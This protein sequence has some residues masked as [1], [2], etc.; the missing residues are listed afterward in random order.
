[1]AVS[2][3]SMSNIIEKRIWFTSE[4]NGRILMLTFTTTCLEMP[5][6]GSGSHGNLNIDNIRFVR[7]C[8]FAYFY[9]CGLGG[10]E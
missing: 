4:F 9:C 7:S 10:P 3:S 8:I 2:L 5:G 6:V 1:M